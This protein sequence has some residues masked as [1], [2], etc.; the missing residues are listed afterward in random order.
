MINDIILMDVPYL[1]RE[2]FRGSDDGCYKMRALL[3]VSAFSSPIMSD[4]FEDIRTFVEVVQ[5]RGFAQ[6]G[7]R[8]GIAKSAISRRVISKIV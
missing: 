4:K 1:A 8:L 6:A 3:E 2:S 5:A 7:K